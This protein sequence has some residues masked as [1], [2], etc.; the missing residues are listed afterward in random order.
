MRQPSKRPPLILKPP[1]RPASNVNWA[2]LWRDHGADYERAVVELRPSSEDALH[3]ALVFCLL[4]G[5]GVT[6]E[7]ALSA[8]RHLA[9]FGVLSR[10]RTDEELRDLLFAELSRPQFEPR[11]KDGTFRR[12]RYPMRKTGLIVCARRWLLDQGELFER[13]RSIPNERARRMFLTAC[14]GV[15]LKTASWLLRNAG[16]AHELAVLDIH[17]LRVMEAQGRLGDLRVPQDYERIEEKFLAWCRE[18]RAPPAAFDFFLW[19][20]Q[21][22]DLSLR[23]H[24]RAA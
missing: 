8:G 23:I 21:R 14:P 19:E 7:L 5:H 10:R 3:D 6:F 4:S 17:V 15:G 9:A 20:A 24:A 2:A 22:G 16:L 13:L 1:D 12:F 11:R 18:L